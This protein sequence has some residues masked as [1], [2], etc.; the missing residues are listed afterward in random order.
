MEARSLGYSDVDLL[1]SY[2]SIT[3]KD[4]ANAWAYA[5]ANPDEIELG[6]EH[7]EVA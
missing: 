4:L 6:I 3:A 5:A 2:P 7:N 1:T